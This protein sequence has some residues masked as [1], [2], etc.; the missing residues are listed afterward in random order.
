MP[1]FL[2]W[3]TCK[4]ALVCYDYDFSLRHYLQLDLF[5]SPEDESALN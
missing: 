2:A 1:L 5:H 4:T 3:K